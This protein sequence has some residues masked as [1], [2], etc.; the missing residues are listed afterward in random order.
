QLL[1]PIKNLKKLSEESYVSCIYIPKTPK[2]DVI[3]EGVY[4]IDADEFHNAGYTGNG[5]KIAIIDAGF[6]GY[7]DLLGSELPSTVVTK[8][9]YN[10]T[11]GNG[12]ITGEG[13]KHG[14]AVAE[15]VHDVA[16]DAQLYFINFNSTVEFSSAVDYAVGEGVKIINHSIGWFDYPY[17]GTGTICDISRNA[18]NNGILWVNSAGNYAKQHY[19]GYFKD[20][21]N[22]NSHEFNDVYETLEVKNVS[23]GDTIR[24]FLSWNDWPYSSNDY[25]FFLLAEE[26]QSFV[27]VDSSEN[28][29]TGSQTPTESINYA[30][31]EDG[32]YYLVVR[33]YNASGNSKI[34]IYSL[35]HDLDFI[36]EE[37]SY[38]SS[39]VDPGSAEEVLTVGATSYIFNNIESYSSQGPTND[40]RIKP[41]VVAPA[42]ISNYTYS[43]Y[44]AGTSASAPHVAGAAALLLEEDASRTNTDLKNLLESQTVDLGDIGKDNIFGNGILNLSIMPLH[45][46]L[47]TVADQKESVP[48]KI[49]VTPNWLGDTIT[50]LIS[51]N[52]SAVYPEGPQLFSTSV[53]DTFTITPDEAKNNA[54]ISVYKASDYTLLG[55]SNTFNISNL[56]GSDIA[57]PSNLSAVDNPDDAGGYI[58]LS[59]TASA[60]HPGYTATSGYN[61]D[62][63]PIDYYQVYR[64]SSDTSFANAINW[65]VIPATPKAPGQSSTITS[66]IS[67]KGDQ[68]SNAFY[69]VAA[70]KGELPPSVTEGVSKSSSKTSN[71]DFIESKEVSGDL[72]NSKITIS[73]II[74]HNRA[75]GARNNT[76]HTADFNSD[77][78][79]GLT[80]FALLNWAID[81]PDEYDRMFDLNLDGMINTADYKIF[82]YQYGQT[83]SDNTSN[84]YQAGTNISGKFELHSEF[85][86]DN[87]IIELKIYGKNLSSVAGYSF[88]LKF[89][90]DIYEPISIS[91]GGFLESQGGSAPYLIKQT[92]NPGIAAISNILNKTNNCPDGEGIIAIVKLRH[93]SDLIES[94]IIE[95]IEIIDN[96]YN[97]NTLDKVI[98]KQPIPIPNQFDLKNNYP[99]PFNPV[100]TIKYEVPELSFVTIKIYNPVGQV[101]RTLV[102]EQK[103]PGYYSLKWDSKN[104]TGIKVSSGIYIYR[105]TTDKG[106]SKAKKMAVMK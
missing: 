89:N 80:D 58:K 37:V 96:Y 75:I 57:P 99:N 22:D 106:F 100:T 14:T 64:N 45:F 26:G 30:V 53:L 42:D 31:E 13:E 56:A 6:N 61:G 38:G 29:Q 67:T 50:V 1:L 41:D 98:L 7:S 93:I 78:K 102:N 24:T 21:D 94:V 60:N 84:I 65:V 73:K 74:G 47:S 8:S 23:I 40:G 91:D 90:P 68:S 85:D 88:K 33:N 101:V 87:E 77:E 66:V 59:F 71:F 25:D 54:V 48:F 4:K 70:V 103:Q 63:I 19:E 92:D 81:N 11:S 72:S 20:T 82:E 32:I 97:L 69:W 12:D 28:S 35:N 86:L 44:F 34:E 36:D 17:D 27:L 104:D 76:N 43:P 49:A 55:Q 18:I 95:N 15:I 2:P 5:V 83:I 3:S 16:P 51:C 9:F 52:F 105:M 39:I 10:S 46:T 79:V 62:T